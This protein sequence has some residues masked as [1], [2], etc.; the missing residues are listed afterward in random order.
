MIGFGDPVFDRT[1]QMTG[2]PKIEALNRSLTSFYRGA[3]ADTMALGK[4][5]AP[6]PETRDELRKVARLLGAKAED[7]KLV[8]GEDATV[9][10]V[11]HERCR[12]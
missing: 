5:L 3:I 6:L 8:V 7:I 12:L 2:R 10:D 11:E 1:V 9:T 4:R